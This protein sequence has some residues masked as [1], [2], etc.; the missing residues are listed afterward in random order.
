MVL[1]TAQIEAAVAFYRAIGFSFTEEKHGTGPVHYSAPL[2]SSVLEIFPGEPASPP[3]RKASGATMVGF[4]VA[5][6]DEVISILKTLGTQIIT[7]PTD[8]PWG[9]RAVVV[10]PDGRGI[11]LTESNKG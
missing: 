6:V 8:S 5:S 3:N 9:R 4:S 7:A 1:R 11:E 10:D 2:G